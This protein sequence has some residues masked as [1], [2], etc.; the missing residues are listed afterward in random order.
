MANDEPGRYTDYLPYHFHSMSINSDRNNRHSSRSHSRD[1]KSRRHRDH[2]RERDSKRRRSPHENTRS[3]HS[4]SRS[5]KDRSKKEN[6]N[7]KKPI[8]KYKYWDVPPAGFEHITP[9]QYKAMQCKTKKKFS[10]L[11]IFY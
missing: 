10:F 5:P 4:R 6:K 7:E 1:R 11:F 2:S 3:K 9:V 8:K